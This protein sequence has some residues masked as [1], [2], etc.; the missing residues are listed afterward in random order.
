MSRGGGSSVEDS[1]VGGPA[2]DPVAK[3]GAIGEQCSQHHTK[4][5]DSSYTERWNG[6]IL[7]IHIGRRLN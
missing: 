4:N 7:E 5:R 6:E 3:K 1:L 2:G